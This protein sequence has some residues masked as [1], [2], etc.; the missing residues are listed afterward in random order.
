MHITTLIVICDCL[1]E[2]WLRLQLYRTR[3]IFGGGKF[4][5]T[6]QVK[7]IDNLVNK[8]QSVHMPIHLCVSVNIGE[9]NFSEWLTI[10]QFSP[11][12]IFPCMVVAS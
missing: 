1:S 11:A 7:A 8:L 4:W 12:K 9:E 6:V 10:R 5:R 2:N 3:E